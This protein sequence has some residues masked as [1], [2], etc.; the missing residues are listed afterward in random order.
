MCCENDGGGG[1]NGDDGIE[2][3][4]AAGRCGVCGFPEDALYVDT[5]IICKIQWELKLFCLFVC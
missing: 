4:S 3:V 1:D 2:G 5:I